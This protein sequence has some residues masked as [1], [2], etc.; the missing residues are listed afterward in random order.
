MFLVKY[1]IFILLLLV[2][3]VMGEDC[4][5]IKTRK[6]WGGLPTLSVE[7]QIIPV[8]F[9]IIHHTVTSTCTSYSQCAE[10]VQNIQD[11][12]MKKLGWSDIGY[13]FLI[14]N[15]GNIYE[16]VGWHKIGAHTYGYN[17]KSIGIAFIGNFDNALPTTA[18]L[19]AAKKLLECGV[20]KGELSRRYKLFG[21]RQVSSTVSPGLELYNEIQDWDHWSEP[22]KN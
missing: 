21:G 8:K 17:S 16:G 15:D 7:Y 18:A 22:E 14:G 4:P 9:V 10:I 19:D 1:N 5:K 12:H 20:E 3:I 13:N 6:K 2:L 11:Y